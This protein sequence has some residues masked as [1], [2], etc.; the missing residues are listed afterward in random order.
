[1][2]KLYYIVPLRV[3]RYF[4]FWGQFWGQNSPLQ[5]SLLWTA[6]SGSRQDNRS[7]PQIFLANPTIDICYAFAYTYR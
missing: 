2:Y 5:I 6:P 4:L 3:K 7:E 1:M